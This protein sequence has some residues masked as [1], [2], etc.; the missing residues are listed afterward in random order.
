MAERKTVDHPKQGKKSKKVRYLKMIV[1]DDLKS[2]TITENAKEQ[3][4]NTADLT[5]CD[6]TELVK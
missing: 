5:T 2:D 4:E 1:I 6:S 3:V